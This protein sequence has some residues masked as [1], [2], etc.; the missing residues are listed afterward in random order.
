[1]KYLLFIFMLMTH[2]QCSKKTCEIKK[3][4]RIQAIKGGNNGFI[5]YYHEVL[6]EGLSSSC[7]DSALVLNLIAKYIDT[8]SYKPIGG[9][10]IFKSKSGYD[11][12]E[13]LSQPKEYN[14]NRVLSIRFY[15]D[16]IRPREFLFLKNGKVI[17]E[18]N[19]WF[20]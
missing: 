14:N 20:K 3:V 8:S 6:M 1:M 18:G 19:K 2:L 12:G 17:Y 13:T 15:Q 11:I 16:S 9:I 5:S 10:G 4:E 7:L